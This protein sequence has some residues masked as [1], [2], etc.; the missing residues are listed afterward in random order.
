M[1]SNW[2]FDPLQDYEYLKNRTSKHEKRRALT[3]DEIKEYYT[4]RDL[5]EESGAE[6]KDRNRVLSMVVNSMGRTGT[7]S[8]RGSA[9]EAEV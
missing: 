1:K 5:I 2:K 8:F 3:R 9:V 7:G 6:L 4:D